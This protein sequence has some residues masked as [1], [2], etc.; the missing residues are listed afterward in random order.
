MNSY[1]NA[2]K[3]KDIILDVK[4]TNYDHHLLFSQL[5]EALGFI[6]EN[7]VEEAFLTTWCEQYKEEVN[8]IVDIL[9]NCML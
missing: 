8:K 5:G 6:N 3:V 2:Q 7:V 1:N 4:R 9:M